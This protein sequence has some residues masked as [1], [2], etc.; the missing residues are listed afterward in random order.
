MLRK[1]L[2]FGSLAA[3]ALAALS[4]SYLIQSKK[5]AIA[6][7]QPPYLDVINV[8]KDGISNYTYS[9]RHRN[10]LRNEQRFSDPANDQLRSPQ[11]RSWLVTKKTGLDQYD[12]SFTANPGDRRSSYQVECVVSCGELVRDCMTMNSIVLD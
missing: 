5:C 9:E 11:E 12:V 6:A 8:V 10:W 2:I 1:S 7:S 4:F 3:M